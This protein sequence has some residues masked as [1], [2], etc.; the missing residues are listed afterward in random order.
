MFSQAATP[1]SVG[2]RSLRPMFAA[3]CTTVHILN[4]SLAGECCLQT[5]HSDVLSTSAAIG[6]SGRKSVICV[7]FRTLMDFT[8]FRDRELQI[9]KYARSSAASQSPGSMRTAAEGLPG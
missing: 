8:E 6:V 9:R 1:V 3:I 5:W 7:T 2:A 4:I